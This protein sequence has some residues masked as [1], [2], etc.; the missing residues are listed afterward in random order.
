MKRFLK[1]GFVSLFILGLSIVMSGC[2]WINEHY[3][4]VYFKEISAD[5]LYVNKIMCQEQGDSGWSTKFDFSDDDEEFDSV[6]DYLFL[7]AGTYK[8]YIDGYYLESGKY[9]F[10][11]V[12]FN[13]TSL[14]D[15]ITVN[16]G[17]D[18]TLYFNSKMISTD[19]NAVIDAM[20]E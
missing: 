9:S 20:K 1:I 3:S 13:F 18:L 12:R 5:R 16:E 7:R 11:A 17:E 6:K 10:D 2:V 8:F 4:R 15:Y 19:K 14:S